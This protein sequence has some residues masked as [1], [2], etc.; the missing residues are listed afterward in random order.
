MIRYR[1]REKPSL[2]HRRRHH[3]C[4]RP[5]ISSRTRGRPHYLRSR[6][7]STTPVHSMDRTT[8]WRTH[9]LKRRRGI[10]HPLASLLALICHR[11]TRAAARPRLGVTRTQLQA[12]PPWSVPP[13]YHEHPSRCCTG[14]RLGG[15]SR[16]RCSSVRLSAAGVSGM[17]CRHG[18]VTAGNSTSGCS[19]LHYHQIHHRPSSSPLRR[20]TRKRRRSPRRQRMGLPFC[21]EAASPE[22]FRRFSPLA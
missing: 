18:R 1:Q 22:G 20:P 4:A 13:R 9:P 17:H 10:R 12:L 21:E 15:L 3:G 16:M 5:Q 11:E 7:P 14:R 6:R 8:M 2:P 19:C